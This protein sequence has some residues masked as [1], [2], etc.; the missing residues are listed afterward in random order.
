MPFSRGQCDSRPPP[1]SFPKH[2]R[3]PLL[4][5]LDV[6]T[7]F[8]HTGINKIDVSDDLLHAEAF[9]IRRDG[10][11][12]PGRSQPVLSIVRLHQLLSRECADEL[13]QSARD[14]QPMLHP[15][16]HRPS[17]TAPAV[18]SQSRPKAFATARSPDGTASS[19]LR[20]WSCS[21]ASP[22]KITSL[23]IHAVATRCSSIC[24]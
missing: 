22:P 17:A 3:A 7:S 14:R 2:E 23:P 5:A 13:S 24:L 8:R 19:S 15:P 4:C 11:V 6:S 18:P 20:P 16:L 12:K 9:R 21:V 1:N 10:D